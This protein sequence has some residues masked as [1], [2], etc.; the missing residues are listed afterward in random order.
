MRRTGIFVLVCWMCYV[1]QIAALGWIFPSEAIYREVNDSFSLLCVLDMHNMQRDA[2][3]LNSSHLMFYRGDEPVPREQV[4]ILNASTIELT[5]ERAVPHP[6]YAYT[7]KANDTKGVAMRSVIIGHK[8]REVKDFKCRAPLWDRQM[9]CTF[10]PDPNSM[11]TTYDLVFHFSPIINNFTCMLE[12]DNDTNQKRCIIDNGN[13]YRHENEYYYFILTA[14]NVLATL[15]QQFVINHFDVVVPHRPTDCVISDITS[16]SAVLTWNQWYK[17]DTF[18]RNFICEVKLLTIFDNYVWRTVSNDGLRRYHR[19]YTLPLRNLPYAAMKYDVRI[20]MRTN[21]TEE[22]EDMWSNHSSCLFET[23]SRKPDLPPEVAIGSFE[24]SN[25]HHLFVYWREIENWQHNARIGFYYNITMLES[26]RKVRDHFNTSGSMIDLHHVKDANYTFIIRSANNEGTSEHSSEIFVPSRRHRLEKP[27]INMLLSDSGKFTLSWQPP[28][29]SHS[30]ITSYTVFW[31]NTTSNSPND[32]NGSINF[33]TVAPDQT[34]YVLSDAGSS[35][36]FAVAANSGQLSSGMV[37]AA[38]T[39]THKTDIGK[40]KTIWITNMTARR[41]SLKWKTEC[42][43]VAHTGY[44]IYYCPIITPRKLDCKEPE[45]T[46]NVTDKNHDNS[47]LENLKPYVTYKI[48]I[49]M[50]SETHI[51]PRS[52]PL[53]NTTREAAPSPPRNLMVRDVTNSSVSLYWQSPEHLNGGKMSYEILY[54]NIILPYNVEEPDTNGEKTLMGLDAFTE[55]NI[56]VRAITTESSNLSLPVRVRTLVGNPQAIRQP[57]T[58]SSND[59]TKLTISWNVPSK[60]AGCVEFYELQVKTQ[61][62]VIFY[63]RKTE[64]QLRKAICQNGD[65]SKYE[66]LVRAVNVDIEGSERHEFEQLSCNNRWKRLMNIWPELANFITD[67]RECGTYDTIHGTNRFTEVHPTNVRLHRGPWSEPLAHW[68]TTD[69]KT[70]L[71][72][73]VLG[74]VIMLFVPLT[75]YSYIRVKHVWQVKVIIPEG[76][77]DITVSGKPTFNTVIG[78]GGIIFSEHHRVDH[79]ITSGSNKEMNYSKEQNQCLLPSS[80]SSG[81]SIADLSGNDQRSSADYCSN[82][83]CCEDD[84][85]SFYDQEAERQDLQGFSDETT[86]SIDNSHSQER[87]HSS[88]LPPNDMDTSSFANLQLGKTSSPTLLMSMENGNGASQSRPPMMPI[89]ATSGYVPAPV[90]SSIKQQP[91]SSNGYLQI[92]ALNGSMMAPMD[93]M[94]KTFNTKLA[95]APISGYVTHKQLSDYGQ[96]LK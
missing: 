60:P 66:F 3:G 62:T 74:C 79:I 67:G 35:L 37:W 14:S 85:T 32:C 19:E 11:A 75:A 61:Q 78:A 56:A 90:M 5:V 18:Q 73:L 44:I 92:G 20:R 54:N 53:V 38:C 23:L 46:V 28:S 22:G 39:A 6:N 7:C 10:T 55:Y 95:T 24:N 34:T 16:D 80:S 94:Q 71:L 51:G 88:R 64:C 77:N 8:P 42:G 12:T 96:H 1:S 13:S 33:T 59:S 72:P 91:I 31:C 25:E 87:S 49:A 68:C 15:S 58:N 82:S 43:D 93:T 52:D 69:N 4:K 50:Y 89:S 26:D 9:I 48:E 47:L 81:G 27:V 2:R 76:L 65:S 41:I 30:S 21:S 84:S 83:G 40:L 63:Q 17:Y 57:S 36:N 70:A 45:L 86:D 29:R